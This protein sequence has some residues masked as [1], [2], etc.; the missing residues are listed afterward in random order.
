MVSDVFETESREGV[1]QL[2]VLISQKQ[3]AIGQFL[4]ARK[5]I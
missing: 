3:L 4:L 2:R 1:M 5:P